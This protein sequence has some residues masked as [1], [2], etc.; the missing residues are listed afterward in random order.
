MNDN[1]LQRA[2]RESGGIISVKQGADAGVPHMTLLRGVKS[3]EL[4][5]V[6]RGVYMS[7][8]ELAYEMYIA[9]L[10]R[11]KI[12]F[13]HD[14]ALLL[15]DLSDRYPL[16]HS[17]TV[18]TGYNTKPLTDDGFTRFSVKRELFQGGAVQMQTPLGHTVNTY[19]LERTIVDCVRS[20]NRM[21]AET[22]SEAVKRYAKRHDKNILR[23][24]EYAEMFGVTKL[25]RT[26]MEV[27]L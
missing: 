14:S 16:S 27:L 24:P 4:E 25:I 3:G 17:V 9:Q 23:L 26:Y 21:E 19:D 10:R 20:R 7:P 11:P 8:D 18:P 13:S 12:V 5:R 6:A 22:V 2:I 15:H 1:K